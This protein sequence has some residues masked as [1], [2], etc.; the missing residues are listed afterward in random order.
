MV[1]TLSALSHDTSS[2]YSISSLG[3]ICVMMKSKFLPDLINKFQDGIR[4]EFLLVFRN[5][6]LYHANMENSTATIP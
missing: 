4:L 3:T 6:V 2:S 5:S 1:F